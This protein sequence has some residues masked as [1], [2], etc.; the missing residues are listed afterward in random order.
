MTRQFL[1][2]HMTLIDSAPGRRG[3]FHAPTG[4]RLCALS[5]HPKAS[6]APAGCAPAAASSARRWRAACRCC[7]VQAKPAL[8]LSDTR[9]QCPTWAVTKSVDFR[10]L[11]ANEAHCRP[12][13]P[14]GRR[15]HH[16]G[17]RRSRRVVAKQQE[18]DGACA[19]AHREGS[20]PAVAPGK[21][22]T[23]T[24]QRRQALWRFSKRHAD[25]ACGVFKT[26]TSLRP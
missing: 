24:I 11:D 2:D 7:S 5:G 19:V 23:A 9:L 22:H 8:Q 20:D 6:R 10:R 16:P 18:G 4:S 13:S 12:A 17:D 21:R 1:V 3:T 15:P 25:R 14:I 26:A